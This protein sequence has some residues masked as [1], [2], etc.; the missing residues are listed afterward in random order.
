MRGEHHEAQI[1]HIAVLASSALLLALVVGQAQSSPSKRKPPLGHADWKK[2]QMTQAMREAA[3]ARTKKK[4]V[5]L[6]KPGVKVNAAAANAAV[7]GGTPD[8]LRADPNLTNSPLPPTVT[9]SDPTGTGAVAEAT[10][11]G[12]VATGV[13]VLAPG[14]GYTSPTVSIVGWDGTGATAGATLDLSGGI[15]AVTVTNGGS[16]YGGIRKFVDPLTVPPVATP[17]TTTYPGSDYY[18][19]E[20][21]KSTQQLHSDLLP[22]TLRGYRQTN[23]GGT[24]FSY[25][26]PTIVAQRDRPVRV[27]FTNSLPRGTGGNLFLPVDTSVMGAGTGPRAA[28]HLQPEPPT[29]HLH[30]GVTPWI[31]DGTAHQWITPAGETTQYPKGVSARDVPDMTG[32]A[33]ANSGCQTFYYTNQQSARLMFYHDHAFGITRLNVY[34]GEA[35]GYL[36]SDP[37]EQGLLGGYQQVPLIIQDKTFVPSAAQLAAE[38]PTWDSAKWGALGNLW[39]PHVYMPNQNP[40]SINGANA[41]G[42]WDYGPWFWPPF[43]GIANGPVPNPLAGQPGEAAQNPG[44]PNPTIVP[45]AFMDTPL[46]N[47]TA[48]PVMNVDPQTYRFRVLDAANDRYW[49]LSFWQAKSQAAMWN[50]D[51]TLAD[52]NAGEINMVP[53]NSSQNAITPFPTT[54]FDGSVQNPFDDRVGGVPNPNFAGPS[55]IQ[56]G[57]EGGLLPKSVRIENQ[58]VNYV[59]NKRDITV[60][61]VAQKAL[62]LGPAERADVLVDFSQFA[63]KTLVLYNDAP[64]PVPAADPRNDYFTGD[65]DQTSTGGAPT[66]LPGYG[67]NTRTI[68]LIHVAASPV[69][70]PL[71]QNALDTGLGSVYAQ[72]QPKPVVG[73]VA[74]N[75]AFGTIYPADGFARIQDTK[76]SFFNGP[77]NGIQLTAAGNGYTSVPS[78]SVTGGGGSGATATA[79]L[80]GTTVASL[81]L[82]S[83]GSGYTS[84]PT[85][86]VSGGGGTGA[87]ATASLSTRTVAT[88]TVTNQG[89]GYTSVPTVA[90]SGGGGSGATATAV[91]VNRKVTAINVTSS[92][93]GYTGAPTVTITG[94]G[95][96]GA[97][98]TANLAPASLAGVTVVNPGSGYTSAPSVAFSGGGGSGAAATA[99][100]TPTSVA[101]I[102]LTAGGSLYSSAP[103]VSI[104]GGGGSGATASCCRCPAG[105]AAQVDHRELRFRLRSHERTPR[106]RDPEYDRSQPNVDPVPLQPAA[107]RDPQAR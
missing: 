88:V 61:N 43:T 106:G 64:A 39:L 5:R 51:G 32:C 36:E 47:G 20:L 33:A 37:L 41:M 42:R 93:S 81:T 92:G 66:T 25:L 56:V 59:M 60:G 30:G 24:P 18:E 22:T 14:V 17:D 40:T 71:D 84:A 9:I 95:G 78:V 82:T 72:S 3:A 68:M 89:N 16:G 53:W 54:W 65:P 103:A 98:A 101:S 15:G 50:P 38:D 28:L 45:E 58:P 6:H 31:S 107:H 7:P 35:A 44:T 46:V 55:F 74:Y 105:H 76:M 91:V 73:Q 104:T 10:V 79:T 80:T 52:G 77:L 26:G 8:D 63:G 67:P 27:K 100:L 87:T 75:A 2:N 1:G 86:T 97:R 99:V 11:V 94:G 96:S 21:G 57:T 13:T 90:F 49:N 23:M 12:G 83:P 85:V 4:G 70:A 34:A 29:L 69:G 102:A 19:I 48:Y 62:F